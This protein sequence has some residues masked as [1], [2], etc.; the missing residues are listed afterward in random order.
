MDA[1]KIMNPIDQFLFSCSLHSFVKRRMAVNEPKLAWIN[2]NNISFEDALHLDILKGST[3]DHSYESNNLSVSDYRELRHSLDSLFTF[4]TKKITLEIQNITGLAASFS[5]IRNRITMDDF[6]A[7]D[8]R[9]YFEID[10]ESFHKNLSHQ[11]ISIIHDPNTNDHFSAFGWNP[12]LYLVNG[13]GGSHHFASMRYIASHLNIAFYLSGLLKLV[14]LDACAVS[15]FNNK[16]SGYL[17]SNDDQTEIRKLTELYDLPC[18]FFRD[19]KHLPYNSCLLFFKKSHWRLFKF[20]ESAIN[21]IL[22]SFNSEL[23]KHLVFQQKNKT[24][25]KYHKA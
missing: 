24:F 21:K 22:I 17:I 7:Q 14:Y 19:S 4:Q 9:E 8:C 13:D 5:D 18:V 2:K 16:Y 3:D 23:E 6:I 1:F 12:L 20:Q 25:Q 11:Q 15:D 10:E